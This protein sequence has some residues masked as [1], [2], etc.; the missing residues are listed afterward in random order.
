MK[1]KRS[2]QAEKRALVNTVKEYLIN[3]ALDHY[4][5]E[6]LVQKKSFSLKHARC[7]LEEAQQEIAE[8]SLGSPYELGLTKK[9]L[10]GLLFQ[11]NQN[12]DPAFALQ[13]IKTQVTTQKLKPGG[14]GYDARIEATGPSPELEAAI[15]ALSGTGETAFKTSE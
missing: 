15:R 13:V 11:A 7:Y 6:F 2:T 9:R 14:K 10:D 4:I 5:L 3:G 1:G 12:K 8:S